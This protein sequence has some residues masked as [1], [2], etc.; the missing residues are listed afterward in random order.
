MS[1][2]TLD[3]LDR[4]ILN[5]L[6]QDCTVPARQIAEQVHASAPTVLRR[7]R[8]LRALGV[9]DAEVAMLDPYALGWGMM[10]FV[11][12]S[13]AD[14]SDA[15]LQ[16][17]EARVRKAPEVLQCYFV[18]GEYDYFLIVHVQDM[19]AYYHFIRG[20]SSSGNLRHYQSRFPMKRIKFS[21]ALRL[22]EQRAEFSV[23]APP[24]RRRRRTEA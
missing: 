4:K 10:A 13:L 11:E 20:L 3:R 12:V 16:A 24:A 19:D 15:M 18:S 6:Q 21:T 17:F 14:Q 7:M 5:L 22:D 9:I 2:L 1:D 23:K 8:E